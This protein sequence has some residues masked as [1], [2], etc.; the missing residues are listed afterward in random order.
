MSDNQVAT[1]EEYLSKGI[2]ELEDII[3]E[4]EEAKLIE[5]IEGVLRAS[6]GDNKNLFKNF[7]NELQRAYSRK[8]YTVVLNVLVNQ[9]LGPLQDQVSAKLETFLQKLIRKYG[10][11]I[12]S[13]YMMLYEPHDWKFATSS[14]RENERGVRLATDILRWDGKRF[15]IT[16]DV[17]NAVKL[18]GHIIKNIDSRINI[19][20]VDPSKLVTCLEY[21]KGLKKL[22]Q[23]L[24]G[25]AKDQVEDSE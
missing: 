13:G 25:K 14:S 12:S 10:V 18:A 23:Q 21:T 8:V 9:S 11:V 6:A 20:N 1:E 17:P 24:K 5:M 7:D 3:K 2:S 4:G 19:N 16:A 15:T 22:I